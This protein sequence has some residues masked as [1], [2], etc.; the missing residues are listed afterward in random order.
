MRNKFIGN[1]KLSVTILCII[2]C[3]T[4]LH[5]F[6]VVTYGVWDTRRHHVCNL[7]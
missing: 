4:Y 5:L 7:K 1:Y 2:S 3:V 6:K